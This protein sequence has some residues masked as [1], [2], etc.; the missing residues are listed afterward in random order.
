MYGQGCKERGESVGKSLGP[1]C[2]LA[3]I[4]QLQTW[5]GRTINAINLPYI[6]PLRPPDPPIEKVLTSS[7]S[8]SSFSSSTNNLIIR[9]TP[10]LP[11]PIWDEKVKL[12]NLKVASRPLIKL[13]GNIAGKPV[14]FLLD[15]G[16]TNEFVNVD[17]VNQHGL[18]TKPCEIKVQ[19]A[20]GITSPSG[21]VIGS[22]CSIQTNSGTFEFRN[23]FL[24]TKL[25]GYDAILG[26]PWLAKFNPEINWATRTVV[27]KDSEGKSST[28]GHAMKGCSRWTYKHANVKNT[29]H[30]A[31][32]RMQELAEWKVKDEIEWA[33]LILVRDS[34]D[35]GGSEP[36]E[37]ARNVVA[38]VSIAQDESEGKRIMDGM[39]VEFA[40]A[41][42]DK[43]PGVLPPSRGIEHNIE[44]L[45]GTKPP[46]MP[47]YRQSVKEMDELKLQ[48]DALI[49]SKFIRPSQ[50]PFGAPVIFVKKKDGTLRLCVDYRALN[51]IT[52]KNKYPLPRMDE[53][54]D[55]VQGAKYFSKIDLRTGF[56]QIRIAD[57]DVSKTAF[58]TRYGHYEY[59]VLPMGLTNAPATDI[60]AL[61]E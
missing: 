52:V 56:H 10:T 55:R 5:N 45:P 4:N 19:L 58:R 30:C 9:A 44:L 24:V 7:S 26:L 17:F 18:V 6:P 16:A 39:L 20:N 38:N 8:L 57:E 43:L 59:M 2:S 35:L 37:G 21:G 54:F 51:N 50:S 1:V 33:S 27:M 12:F 14:N 61:N 25:Y 28:L 11:Q 31:V 46:S 48:L 60:H 34:K 36:Q 29:V 32:I 22:E 42:P 40:D 47:Y 49:K 23:E 41:F 3:K 15:C 53:L 13:V